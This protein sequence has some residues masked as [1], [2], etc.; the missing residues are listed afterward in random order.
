MASTLS[1]ASFA[2]SPAGPPSRHERMAGEAEAAALLRAG[3]GGVLG[4]ASPEEFERIGSVLRLVSGCL[5]NGDLGVLAGQPTPPFTR[6][7][8]ETAADSIGKTTDALWSDA[9]EAVFRFR[10]GDTLGAASSL[11]RALTRYQHSDPEEPAALAGRLL[12]S[13]FVQRILGL[14]S[15]AARTCRTVEKACL[16]EEAS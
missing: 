3:V 10:R 1:S 11:G 9:D 2:T 13:Y 14:A 6:P 4:D 7:P 5:P 8:E 16:R 15:E 12:L